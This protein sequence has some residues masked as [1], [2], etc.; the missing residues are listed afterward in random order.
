D[1]DQDRAPEYWDRA[2]KRMRTDF[3]LLSGLN[4]GGNVN[5]K[6]WFP[7]NCA[8]DDAASKSPDLP[9]AHKYVAGKKGWSP[10]QAEKMPA[11]QALLMYMQ[12]TYQ[13]DRDDWYR[14]SYLRYPQALPVFEAA[15]KRLRDAPITEAHLPARLLL[16]A[17]DR[18]LSRQMLLERNLAALQ[19]IE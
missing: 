12:G 6:D 9:A 2:L 11:A 4:E 1:S 7:K 10:E 14:A 15:S 17:L 16:S 18:V 13:V 5:A 3:Q 19:A 8:P